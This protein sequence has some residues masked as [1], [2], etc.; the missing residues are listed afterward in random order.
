MPRKPQYSVVLTMTYSITPE[1]ARNILIAG[2]RYHNWSNHATPEE[3]AEIRRVWDML[4]GAASWYT[5][6]CVLAIDDY[7]PI[8]SDTPMHSHWEACGLL[9]RKAIE[10]D[11]R[12]D[13]KYK[14]VW[15]FLQILQ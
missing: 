14:D 4:N 1:A 9:G 13:E 8:D 12:L 7:P 2:A 3:D 11:G 10:R 15:K 6:L 5:A